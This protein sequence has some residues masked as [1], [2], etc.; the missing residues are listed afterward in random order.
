MIA[1]ILRT[2]VLAL[3]ATA[4]AWAAYWLAHERPLWAAV[5]AVVIL[6]AHAP[7]LA[8]EFAMLTRLNRGDASPPARA[9]ELLRAW[10]REVL[11]GIVVFAWRQPFRSRSQA[12]HLPA[13]ARGQIGRASCRERV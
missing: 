8:F 4:L 12:D 1:R 11:A 10:W 3:I 2:T 6:L 7:V 9:G 13:D 5:G